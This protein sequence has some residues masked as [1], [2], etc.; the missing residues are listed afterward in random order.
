[1]S[2]HDTE[3]LIEVS[4]EN[5]LDVNPINLDSIRDAADAHS[6]GVTVMTN[7][8]G[9]E[10]G[11]KL[12]ALAHMWEPTHMV[13]A[14]DYALVLYQSGNESEALRV[15]G[16]VDVK[17]HYCGTAGLDGYEC[18]RVGVVFSLILEQRYSALAFFEAACELVADNPELKLS[19]AIELNACGYEDDAAAIGG[20]VVASMDTLS[21]PDG[22]DISRLIRGANLLANSDPVAATRAAQKA[23][24]LAPEDPEVQHSA[25]CIAGKAGDPGAAVTH[26]QKAIQL[27]PAD[28]FPYCGMQVELFNLGMFEEAFSLGKEIIKGWPDNSEVRFNNASAALNM[29]WHTEAENEFLDLL[30]CDPDDALTHA[31]LGLNYALTG[32]EHEAREHQAEALGLDGESPEVQ[33]ISS[34]IDRILDTEPGPSTEELSALFAVI[35]ATRFRRRGV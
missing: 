19:Y 16:T 22:M 20:A 18:H 21:E 9:H 11:V 30:N 28:P 29:G 25:G 34:R 33:H 23:L 3:D 27:S 17:A 8:P 4:F 10:Q 6:R 7:W 14:A 24:R 32:R 2:Q 5:I 13:Y 12:F 15:A 31:A 26:F 1:M 35:L